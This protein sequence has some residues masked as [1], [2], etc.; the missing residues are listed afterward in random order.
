MQAHI[1]QNGPAFHRFGVLWTPTVLLLD[2][3]GVER[4]R[5]EGYLP[6]EEFQ[7]Q[8]DLGRARLAFVEKRWQAAEDVYD[9]VMRQWPRTAA[10]ADAIYWHAVCFYKRTQDHTSLRP[11]AERLRD[12]YPGSLAAKRAQP[13]LG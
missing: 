9:G 3:G 7:A 4:F 5:L 8:L 1:K 12:D 2:A 13:F 6:R 10:A 11:M